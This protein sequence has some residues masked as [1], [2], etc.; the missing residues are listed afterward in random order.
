MITI[1]FGAIGAG[2]TALLTYILWKYAFDKERNRQ[3]RLAI[4]AQNVAKDLSLSIPPHCVAANYSCTFRKFGYSPRHNR[5]IDPSRLG[6]YDESSGVKPHFN[7]PY[8]VIGI[9]EAQRWFCGKGKEYLKPWQ[10]RFFELHR[11]T[12]LD[13]LLA[14]QRAI[15]IDKNIRDLSQGIEV[16]KIKLKTD[17]YGNI[18]KV[19]WTVNVINEGEIDYY[20]SASKKDQKKYYK[21]ELFKANFNIFDMYNS[22]SCESEFYRGHEGEDLDLIYGA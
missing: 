7:F 21:K 6:I 11:H 10:S 12:H 4:K 2:K 15:L 22:F 18:S 17:R 20:L 8:E 16:K 9:D 13:I 5:V 1:I 3:M 14:C 19:I